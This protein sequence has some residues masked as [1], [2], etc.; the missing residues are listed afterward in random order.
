MTEDYRLTIVIAVE[1]AQANLPAILDQLTPGRYPQVQFL[2]CHGEQDQV[3]A[4]LTAGWDNVSILA[5]RSSSRIP[6]LWRDGIRAARADLIATTTAHCIPQH[7]WVERLLDMKLV[8]NTVAV[9]GL[10]ANDANANPKSWAI[11]MLRYMSVAPPQSMREIDDVAADNALYRRRDILDHSDLLQQ[12][13]WEPSFHARFRDA[14]LR[15]R[16]DPGLRVTQHNLYTAAEFF[17]QRLIHGRE[18]GAGR[19]K[20]AGR[21][22][23]RLLLLV[24]PAL[25]LVFLLKILH[26]V[27]KNTN[28]RTQ[29]V[30]ALPWLLWFL[31]AW[32]LGE[33]RGYLAEIRSK[34]E[35]P[36]D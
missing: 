26:K 16:L 31:A 5:G 34:T 33:A 35:S 29:L 19:A 3:P 23:A 6:H 15:L 21:T 25:P 10:V 14:G 2:I 13:F 24:S 4:S 1:H 20:A 32:G 11:F 30:A 8:G 22:K 27:W 36:S 7:D 17:R 12:G 9:G 28:A 18:F